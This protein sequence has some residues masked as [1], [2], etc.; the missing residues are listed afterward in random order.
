MNYEQFEQDLKFNLLN[1]NA[2]K[3][4][5]K[6]AEAPYRFISFLSPLNF[7]IKLEQAFY[8]SQENKYYKFLSNCSVNIFSESG[9]EIAESR[10]S[11][12]KSSADNLDE[13]II[14]SA[15]F[16]FA[17]KDEENK[18][19]YFIKQRK[20]DVFSANEAIKVWDKFKNDVELAK[21][22]FAD[23]KIIGLL[24]FVDSEFRNNQQYYNSG[25]LVENELDINISAKYGFELFKDFELYE[26]WIEIE[27]H[28]DKFKRQNYTDFLE[29]PNLD[30]DPEALEALIELSETAWEKLN[31]P[32]PV[33]MAVR[34]A[35]F[36]EA[37]ENSNL[38]KALKLRDI[39]ANM[40]DE[41][42]LKLVL[43][44]LQSK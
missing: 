15:R 9:Y 25:S 1:H 8:R 12:T 11:V 14:E 34:S 33:Y 7:K 38:F 19:Y 22:S 18:K 42:E 21:Q 13:K 4:I 39:K 31:S 27:L 24:W 5:Y 6:L 17:F 10:V 16:T 40:V 43:M 23:Y 29:F 37:D 44:K 41:D 2:K 36:N 35:I 30:K 28:L 26:K 32:T 3:L 20:R